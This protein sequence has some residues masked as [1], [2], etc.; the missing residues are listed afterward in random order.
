[1]K[2]T[3]ELI[4]EYNTVMRQ[5]TTNA[6]YAVMCNYSATANLAFGFDWLLG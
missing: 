2:H 6:D 1:M 5:L 3:S 4:N